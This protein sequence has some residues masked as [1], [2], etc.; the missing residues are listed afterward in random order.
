MIEEPSSD[1]SART[2]GSFVDAAGG[3]WRDGRIVAWLTDDEIDF[4]AATRTDSDDERAVV[5]AA[6]LGTAF[7]IVA[8]VLC[9]VYLGGPR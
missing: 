6:L 3:V 1:R 2:S 5:A 8:A 7:G 4:L 9:L